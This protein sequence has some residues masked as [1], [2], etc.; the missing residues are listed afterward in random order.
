MT[1]VT[2]SR[3]YA[4]KSADE[5]FAAA[6]AAL[7][8]VGFEIWKTREIGWL[9]MA[10]REDPGGTVRA[11]FASRPGAVATLALSAE[12]VSE[13]SLQV[14]AEETFAAFQVELG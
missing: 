10:N 4:G 3:T 8:R 9:V 2:E 13:E 12:G 5:C 7:P 1:Q 14:I 11:N 6:R